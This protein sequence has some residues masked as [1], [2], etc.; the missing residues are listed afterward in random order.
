MMRL[1]KHLKIR[2]QERRISESDLQLVED[3]GV[4][5]P[6]NSSI[7]IVLNRKSC[8]KILQCLKAYKPASSSCI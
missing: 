7:H 5:L 3:L 8:E 4:C 1:T 2:M 6:V